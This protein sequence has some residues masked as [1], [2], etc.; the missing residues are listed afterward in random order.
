MQD[1]VAALERQKRVAEKLKIELASTQDKLERSRNQNSQLVISEKA[2]IEMVESHRSRAET[3]EQAFLDLQAKLTEV[4]GALV[5]DHNKEEV[6]LK[7][8]SKLETDSREISQ[9][10]QIELTRKE[11]MERE[12]ESLKAKLKGA[13]D[14]TLM[15]SRR[16]REQLDEQKAMESKVSKENARVRTQLSKILAES[17]KNEQMYLALKKM[18]DKEKSG[19]EKIEDQQKIE[20][21]LQQRILLLE[22]EGKEKDL[23]LKKALASQKREQETRSQ[24]EAQIKLMKSRE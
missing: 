9:K 10:Y 15:K 17:G 18:Y 22:K 14:M 23:R 13:S 1:E 21:E 2:L 19:S 8:L 6:L 5:G 24:M 16:L 7:Q 11:E 3:K 20:Q 4:Q 12:Q